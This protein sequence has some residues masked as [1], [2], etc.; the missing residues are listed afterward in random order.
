ML[1]M[2]FL[3]IQAAYLHQ[4]KNH[5]GEFLTGT[6]ALTVHMTLR[7]KFIFEMRERKLNFIGK[8]FSKL[9]FLRTKL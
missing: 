5:I 3:C 8:L 7:L 4:T 1:V 9:A 6:G 2:L